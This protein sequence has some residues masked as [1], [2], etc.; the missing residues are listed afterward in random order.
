LI[1]STPCPLLAASETT[2]TAADYRALKAD[3]DA[4]LTLATDLQGRVAALETL[5]ATVDT[6]SVAAAATQAQIGG[7]RSISGYLS[8]AQ[9][10]PLCDA[11]YWQVALG[12]ISRD[13][14]FLKLSITV[15]N[16]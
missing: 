3:R 1:K 11:G 2:I 5:P 13:L 7:L 8:A 6:L 10:Y 12:S 4:L 14:S 16:Y 15:K 9:N